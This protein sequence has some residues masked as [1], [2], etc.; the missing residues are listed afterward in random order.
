MKEQQSSSIASARYD[1]V[2][3]DELASRN[4]WFIRL[5][6]RVPPCILVGAILAEWLDYEFVPNAMYI[7]AIAI[8]LYNFVLYHVVKLPEDDQTSARET[9]RLVAYSQVGLDLAALVFFVQFTGGSASPFIFFFFFHAVSAS[10]LL[11]PRSA[12]T[13]VG[14][15]SASI[16]LLACAEYL[17]LIPH[18]AVNFNGT[19]INLAQ[20]PAHIAVELF[21]FTVAL[22]TAAFFT[23][24]MMRTL[25]RGSHRLAR[26]NT[27]NQS[28]QQPLETRSFS[29]AG[30]GLDYPLD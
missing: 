4:R 7:L 5:R 18:H 20:Q 25:R 19:A 10:I 15:A 24:T 3:T 17:Q 30:G 14:A 16:A 29:L 6:W 1:S 8:L 22:F 23:T 9:L 2:L 13:V 26:L 27:D 21:F 28:P 11:A 12:Y